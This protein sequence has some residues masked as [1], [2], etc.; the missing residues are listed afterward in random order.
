MILRFFTP[1]THLAEALSIPNADP[2]NLAGII[3]PGARVSPL[4]SG[5]MIFGAQR[6]DKGLATA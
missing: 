6:F 5:H 2:L 1:T 4:V 3:L